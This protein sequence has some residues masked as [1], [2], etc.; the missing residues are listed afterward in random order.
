MHRLGLPSRRAFAGHQRCLPRARAPFEGPKVVAAA[1]SPH[2]QNFQ[3]RRIAAHRVAE[4][5]VPQL[6]PAVEV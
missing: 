6:A 4:S 2:V 1:E 5:A 3:V